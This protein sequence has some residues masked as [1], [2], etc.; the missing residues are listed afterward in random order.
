MEPPVSVWDFQ[1]LFR[2]C[3]AD[4]LRRATR[5]V[6][7]ADAAADIVQ[8]VFLRLLNAPPVD[9]IENKS[10]YLFRIADNLAIDY[11]RRGR[12]QA[13]RFVSLDV[14][15]NMPVEAPDAETS[16]LFRRAVARLAEAIDELPPRCRRV[17]LLHK[18]DGLTYRE[19]AEKLGISSSMVEKHMMKAIA[20]CRD[21]LDGLHD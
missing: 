2:R 14:V 19:I 21:R 7:S 12:V 1:D 4:L 5:R 9:L 15:Q 10:G 3:G 8:D 13:R 6:G 11:L 18:F 16:L 17:F 20:H